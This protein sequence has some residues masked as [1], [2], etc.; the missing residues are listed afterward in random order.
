VKNFAVNKKQW[1]RIA[2]AIATFV[3]IEV[4]LAKL[5]GET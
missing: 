4:T 2:N 3:N 1:D 5:H